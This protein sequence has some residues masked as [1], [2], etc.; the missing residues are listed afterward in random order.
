MQSFW[1]T[2]HTCTAPSTPQPA[3][4]GTTHVVVHAE[5]ARRPRTPAAAAAAAGS[6]RSARRRPHRSLQPG[7]ARTARSVSRYQVCARE[8]DAVTQLASASVR[9]GVMFGAGNATRHEAPAPAPQRLCAA[10]QGL[11]LSWVAAD[12]LE[13]ALAIPS[14]WGTERT[15]S[16][17]PPGGARLKRCAAAASTHCGGH[18]APETRSRAVLFC[19]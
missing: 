4:G 16:T 14:A 11:A 19:C 13:G 15:G 9:S 17:E 8:P 6:L 3:S 2:F 7:S 5:S 10:V 1:T 12:S 18:F